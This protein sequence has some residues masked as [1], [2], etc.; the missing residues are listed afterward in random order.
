MSRAE[1]IKRAVSNQQNQGKIVDKIHI[2]AN[3]T[4]YS[5]DSVFGK[6]LDENVK[7]ISLEEPYIRDYYQVSSAIMRY[8]HSD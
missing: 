2:I 1:E 7:E 5:Y 3:G 6:Y 4:G 8:R